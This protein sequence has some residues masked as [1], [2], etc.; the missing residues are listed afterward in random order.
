MHV[1]VRTSLRPEAV[2]EVV[3][4]QVRGIDPDLGVYDLRS[5]DA[6]LGDAIAQPRL[7]SLLLWAFAGVASVLSAVGVYG[8]SAQRVSQRR[9]EFAIRMALGASPASVFG[10][11][12]RESLAIGA[13]GVV[14]GLCGAGLLGGALSSVLYGVAANDVV[15]LVGAAAVVL[16]VT[17]L[18]G[19]ATGREGGRRRPDDDPADRVGRRPSVVRSRSRRWR[20]S[21]SHWRS[22]APR[23]R[24][25]ED[26]IGA[27]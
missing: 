12:T 20:A 21:A 27:A 9:R 19:L 5:I 10:M 4:S 11:V 7:N 1:L 8:V 6:I 18:A 16:A 25:P 17:L 14:A 3:Q 15:T 26:R 2:A 23:R 22:R 24:K 13:I